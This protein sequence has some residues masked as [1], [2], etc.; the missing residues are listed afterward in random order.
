[1]NEDIKAEGVQ[2]AVCNVSR[3]RPIRSVVVGVDVLDGQSGNQSVGVV[4]VVAVGGA[5][6][7]G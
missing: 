3:V 1:M 2:Q 4:V 5:V 7:V 6:R